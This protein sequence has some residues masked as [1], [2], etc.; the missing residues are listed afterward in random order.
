MLVFF[1]VFAIVLV[2]NPLSV[3]FRSAASME[4]PLAVLCLRFADAMPTESADHRRLLRNQA[5][6]PTPFLDD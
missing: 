3:F 2:K 5:P 4:L 1:T 6:Q